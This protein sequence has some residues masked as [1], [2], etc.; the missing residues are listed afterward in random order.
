[1]NATLLDL[2]VGNLH[3]LGRALE[4]LGVRCAVSA[5]PLEGGGTLVLP[6]VG[7]FGH[8]ADAL[9]PFRSIVRE[10]IVAGRPTLGI[11]LG[12]QLLFDR[13]EEDASRSGRGLGVLAGEVTRLK[14]R[15]VPHIGWTH[16]EGGRAM[17]FAHSFACRPDDPSIVR[18]WARHDDERFPA[19]LR[20]GS[21]VAT[22]FHPEK[23]STEGLAL[24]KGLLE[25][26]GS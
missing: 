21:I 1:M 25:E 16:L 15:R 12:M 23:S 11:C 20:A 26:L 18:W 3:S 10:Q 2:G 22:Q 6:G 7:A 13:S 5:S 9:A 17:Y 4:H 8:A 14:T 19:A 24:L